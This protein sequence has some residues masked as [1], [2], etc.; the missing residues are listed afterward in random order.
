MAAILTEIALKKEKV[1]IDYDAW[2]IEVKVDGYSFWPIF[3]VVQ[4]WLRYHQGNKDMLV[5]WAMARTFI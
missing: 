4:A 2:R 5:V 3:T 1:E